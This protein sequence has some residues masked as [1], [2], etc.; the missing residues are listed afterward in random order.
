MGVKKISLV[1]NALLVALARSV[2]TAVILAAEILSVVNALSVDESAR[3]RSCGCGLRC[4]A[5]ASRAATSCSL[6]AAVSARASASSCYSCLAESA[7]AVQAAS[8]RSEASWSASH[9]DVEAAALRTHRIFIFRCIII[10][11][12]KLSHLFFLFKKKNYL[13]IYNFKYFK[14]HN[15]LQNTSF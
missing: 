1:F 6:S 14:Q 2:S 11:F 10:F 13:F 8:L 4:R 15:S 5:S 9:P 7:A 12:I 3:T